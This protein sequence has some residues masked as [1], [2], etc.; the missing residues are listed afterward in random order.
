MDLTLADVIEGLSG[1][2][3]AAPQA[4]E[5]VVVDSRQAGEGALFVALPGQ[6]YDGHQ[7]VEQAFQQGAIAAIVQQPVGAGQVINMAEPASAPV[8][9][10]T[11]PVC[12]QVKDSLTGLQQLAAFWRRKF[13][14]RV[15]GI[16]GSVGKSTSKELVWAVLSTKF[17]TLKS[18]GNLNNE[19]GLP[20]TLLNLTSEYEVVVLEM[21]TY[22]IGEI[23]LLCDIA[24]PHVGMVTNVGPTHLE[25]L[26]TVERIAEAKAELVQALPPA[27]E[28]GVAIL[29][30]DD[31]L[32][33]PMAQQ[34]E[35]RVLTYGLSPE[36]DLWASEV[37]SAGL[38]GI[39]FVFHHQDQTI[40]AR[41]PLLGR[42]SDGAT[43][44]FGRPG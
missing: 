17:E 13:N 42:H 27:A 19:I 14:P 33:L 5:K 35:A 41:V 26:G 32:V 36:A 30:Y 34:T 24:Q 3:I 12:L 44:G 1:N 16:T 7:F 18:E 21:G 28:G 43:G 38:E 39:R 2:Q 4:I 22:A 31:P 37:E 15:I 11:L 29:N 23:K 8:A 25:R 9:I 10:N 40:H 20:L 6:K